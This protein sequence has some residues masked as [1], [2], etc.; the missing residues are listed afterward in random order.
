MTTVHAGSRPDAGHGREQ[1]DSPDGRPCYLY[2]VLPAAAATAATDD[3]PSGCRFV[4]HQDL[5]ALVRTVPPASQQSRAQLLGYADTL[6]RLAAAGPVLP[7][8]F[9]TV[10]PAAETVVTDVLAPYHDAYQDALAALAGTTQLVLRLRYRR[11]AVVREVLAEQPAARRLHEQLRQRPSSSDP[12]GR[13][14]L[15]ELVAQAV[16]GKR[17]P[18][19]AALVAEIRPYAVRVHVEPATTADP[20]Q[21]GDVVCLIEQSRQSDFESATA[22]VARGWRDR[23]RVRMLGPMAPYHFAGEVLAGPPSAPSSSGRSGRD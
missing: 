8:R 9:G 3:L 18:D 13:V 12:T 7:I 14:R 5:A 6:D 22:Q 15:G 21:V 4:R 16:A 10:L 11:E 1:E 23:V 2:G 17:A 19:L 20:E